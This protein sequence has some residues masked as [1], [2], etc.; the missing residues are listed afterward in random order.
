MISFPAVPFIH[1]G[2]RDTVKRI[3]D[4]FE[5]LAAS[6]R[7]TPLGSESGRGA[8]PA[9]RILAAVQ[10]INAALEGG[11]ERGTLGASGFRAMGRGFERI[12]ATLLAVT[13]VE[14]KAPAK[15]TAVTKG[16]KKRTARAARS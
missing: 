14:Q 4:E 12:G 1:R 8:E 15:R 11:A 3:A 2:E 5:K 9:K 13:A 6:L 10:S 16:K 7:R